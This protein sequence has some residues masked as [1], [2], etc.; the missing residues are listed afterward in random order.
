MHNIIHPRNLV[1]SQII[2]VACA[3]MHFYFECLGKRTASLITVILTS[4]LGTII[5]LLLVSVG[6]A[7][8]LT[9]FVKNKRGIVYFCYNCSL[10]MSMQ[11][12]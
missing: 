11:L 8:I 10:I 12:M 1:S 4:S 6:A 2:T 5:G 9:I 3:Y 7:V